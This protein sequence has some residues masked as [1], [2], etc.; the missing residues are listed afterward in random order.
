MKKEK[1]TAEQLNTR[2]A[3]LQDKARAVELAQELADV[4][5]LIEIFNRIGRGS[6]KY[7]IE[8]SD[9]WGVEFR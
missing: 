8:T 2:A 4:A 1:E 7:A 5:T 3:E 6:I 9:V